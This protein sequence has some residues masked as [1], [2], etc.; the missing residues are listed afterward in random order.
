MTATD[1]RATV[2]LPDLRKFLTFLP[3]SGLKRDKKSSSSKDVKLEDMSEGDSIISGFD[4]NKHKIGKI[5]LAVDKG[6]YKEKIIA[7]GVILAKGT[8]AEVAAIHV[9]DESTLGGI[10]DVFG[11]RVIE[12]EKAVRK[13]S[14]DLQK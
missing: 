9:F 7:Y 2:Y 5:L 8:G 1:Y 11:T 13:R 3:Y 4:S 6:G 12:Y 14:E 10:G